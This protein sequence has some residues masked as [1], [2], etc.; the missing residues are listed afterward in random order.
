[1]DAEV[2]DA[3]LPPTVDGPRGR[4]FHLDD[5]GVV[6]V[7]PIQPE[8]ATALRR[9]HEGLSPESQY[10]RFFSGHPHLSAAEADHFTRVDH[11]DREAVLVEDGGRIVG[12]GRYDRITAAPVKTAEV[13]FTVTDDHQHRGIGT[14]LMSLLTA[15]AADRGFHHLRAVTLATNRPMQDL[16][17]GAGR[18]FQATF[19]GGEVDYDLDL[20]APM[21]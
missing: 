4:P 6:H 10:R 13:A 14:L 19:E 5:G 3:G 18:P 7:R 2:H 21:T 20:D 8:D 16:V 1:M 15:L 12:V 11:L 9:F 17:M